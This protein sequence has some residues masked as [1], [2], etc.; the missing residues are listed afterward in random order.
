MELDNKI[1]EL[2]KKRYRYHLKLDILKRR[3]EILNKI[4]SPECDIHD[5]LHETF[6]NILKL[7]EKLG[8]ISFELKKEIGERKFLLYSDIAE[9]LYKEEYEKIPEL[10]EKL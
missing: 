10:I 8:K 3:R 9:L 7:L 1:L 2:F 6:L 4:S 5:E